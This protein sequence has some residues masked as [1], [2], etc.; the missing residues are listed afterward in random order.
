[1]VTRPTATHCSLRDRTRVESTRL[2]W[3]GGEFRP[4]ERLQSR[5]SS[6]CSADLDPPLR[7]NWQNIREHQQLFT[8]QVGPFSRRKGFTSALV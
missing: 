6:D 5:S 4:Y 8:A 7:V 2:M 1:M 3:L